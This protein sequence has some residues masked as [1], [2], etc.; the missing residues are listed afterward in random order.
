MTTLPLLAQTDPISQIGWL[1]EGLN[2]FLGAFLGALLGY[3]FSRYQSGQEQTSQRAVLLAH[4]QRELSLLGADAARDER[5]ALSLRVPIRVNV[6]PRLLDGSLLEYRRHATLVEHLIVLEQV[7]TRYNDW[8]LLTNEAQVLGRRS[9]EE[10]AQMQQTAREL[11]AMI[12]TLRDNILPLLQITR[13]Q[14]GHTREALE[15][16]AAPGRSGSVPS[17]CRGRPS[18]P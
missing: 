10:I 16:V 7:I 9:P 13:D 14:L 4:L 15:E 8:A 12:V 6:I 5:Q 11:A 1:T 17:P 2:V 3:G 18:P